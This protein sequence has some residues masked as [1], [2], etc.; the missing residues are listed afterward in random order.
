MNDEVAPEQPLVVPPEPEPQ[1]VRKTI[2][3]SAWLIG[4][5]ILI[6]L[7]I[8]AA[9]YMR[10]NSEASQPAAATPTPTV[11]PS[12]TPQQNLSPIATTSAFA[13]FQTAVASLS[14]AVKSFSVTDPTLNPPILNTTVNFGQ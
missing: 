7:F 12:P 6:G 14:G 8:T 3:K 4:G 1:P 5:A 9:L 2:P 11:I 10:Y 13:A